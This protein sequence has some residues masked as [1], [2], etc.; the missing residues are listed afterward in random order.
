M[1]RLTVKKKMVGDFCGWRTI[2]RN[3]KIPVLQMLLGFPGCT[4]YWTS[5][6]LNLLSFATKYCTR[7]SFRDSFQLEME[8]IASPWTQDGWCWWHDQVSFPQTMPDQVTFP[9][10]KPDLYKHWH[11]T[12]P[13]TWWTVQWGP[14]F[15]LATLLK[16]TSIVPRWLMRKQFLINDK[17]AVWEKLPVVERGVQQRLL[18]SSALRQELPLRSQGEKIFMGKLVYNSYS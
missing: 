4:F 10:T 14:W 17:I 15:K 7:T 2:R 8:G 16:T 11:L 6:R 5:S 18:R 12:E 13:W 3:E 9:Q 1:Q